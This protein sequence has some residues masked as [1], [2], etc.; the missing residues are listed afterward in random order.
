[1]ASK[2][3]LS[4]SVILPRKMKDGVPNIVICGIV[5]AIADRYILIPKKSSLAYQT[6]ISFSFLTPADGFVFILY[7]AV[8]DITEDIAKNT[9]INARIESQISSTINNLDFRGIEAQIFSQEGYEFNMLATVGLLSNK[10]MEVSHKLELKFML[11][12]E[13][14]KVSWDD[15]ELYLSKEKNHNRRLGRNKTL[16]P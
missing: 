5:N 12:R 15:P 8:N 7:S 6:Q 14:I 9:L 16:Y 1:M 13:D 4:T 11:L 3:D 10:L 2:P